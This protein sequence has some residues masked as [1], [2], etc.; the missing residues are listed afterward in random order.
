MR[1]VATK[2]LSVVNASYRTKISAHQLADKIADPQSVD[3]VD[4]SVFAFFTE[5]KPTLQEAFIEAMGV[6]RSR[7]RYVAQQLAA[8]SGFPLALAT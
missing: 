5:V 3:S 8:K 4:A 7:A 2:V 6:D 1:G